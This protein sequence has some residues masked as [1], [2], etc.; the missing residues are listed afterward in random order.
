MFWQALGA[1]PQAVELLCE[2]DLWWEDGNLWVNKEFSG[3]P[4][5]L[6]KVTL[7]IL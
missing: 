2:L 3:A 6:D 4:D 5:M 1:E 7:T